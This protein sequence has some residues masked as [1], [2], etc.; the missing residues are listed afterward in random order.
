[1]GDAKWLDQRGSFMATIAAGPVFRLLG[2]KHLGVPG[3]AHTA[4]MP[5]VNTGLLNGQ[6]AWRQH[7]AG[8]T[9]APNWKYFIP[10]AAK[11]FNYSSTPWELP[12]D[13]SVFRTDANS[14]VAH[15]QLLAKAKQGGIDVYFEGDSITRRWDALDYPNR[16]ANWKTNFTGWNAADFGWV[17]IEFRIFCGV[18][19]TA[20]WRESIRKW[21][22]YLP[23]RITSV[24]RRFRET[25]TQE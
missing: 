12:A 1:M 23:V 15:S 24:T 20:N 4:Q 22:S 18:W 6:L 13:Q 11:F 3:D 17:R 10:W 21:L 19:R 7:D 16:L 25:G 8:H 9:D 2:A 5:P 14:L